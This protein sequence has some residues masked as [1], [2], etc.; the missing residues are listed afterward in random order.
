MLLK[1][2]AFLSLGMCIEKGLVG[3]KLVLTDSTHIRANAAV[4]SEFKV[5]VEQE[6]A[7]YMERLDKYRFFGN[8]DSIFSPLLIEIQF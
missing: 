3:G 7:W 2:A 8:L 6:A 4:N 5:M 1:M